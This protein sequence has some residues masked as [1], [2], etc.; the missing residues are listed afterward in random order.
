MQIIIPRAM[1]LFNKCRAK[2]EVKRAKYLTPWEDQFF[3]LA[4]YPESGM[5]CECVC[6]CFSS[7]SSLPPSSSPSHM[8]S[9]LSKFNEYLE[10]IIQYGFVTLFVAAFP[11][12]PFFAFVNNVLEIRIDGY[13]LLTEL[14]RPPALKASGIGVWFSV[15]EITSFFSVLSNGLVIA[16][17]SSFLAKAVY[18]N[19]HDGSLEGYVDVTHPLSPVNDSS[20]Y[21]GCHYIGLL[22]DD[23]SKG[24]FYYEVMAARIGFLIVFEH[25]IYLAKVFIHWIIPDI[26]QRE[27]ASLALR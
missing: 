3:N 14:R 23:G 20:I 2:K 8:S 10:M 27:F 26:P 17:T 15:L 19:A 16:F 6:V 1:S 13:K 12:A 21:T 24:V 18:S 11:L 7:S 9:P 25:V 22:E 5:V 4:P